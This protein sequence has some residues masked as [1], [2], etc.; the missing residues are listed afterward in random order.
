M[1]VWSIGDKLP[2]ANILND[3]TD[4]VTITNIEVATK[5]AINLTGD[6]S[7]G[8]ERK[9]MLNMDNL[10]VVDGY[11]ITTDAPY[12][13]QF[14][15]SNDWILRGIPEGYEYQFI[16]S[17]MA[18]EF[19][20]PRKPGSANVLTINGDTEVVV[21]RLKILSTT[22]EAISGSSADPK[23]YVNDTFL[24]NSSVNAGVE[25]IGGTQRIGENIK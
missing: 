14:G 6:I 10:K 8:F 11:V 7:E 1:T 15:N 25:V 19:G 12:F 18:S 17:L 9:R 24:T 22:D 4:W 5:P 16:G 21:D 20:I 2:G 3:P 13:N 23:I